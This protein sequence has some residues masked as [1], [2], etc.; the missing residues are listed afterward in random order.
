LV[1]LPPQVAAELGDRD[2][3]EVFYAAP[4][5]TGTAFLLAVA[6]G[7][8]HVASEQSLPATQRLEDLTTLAQTLLVTAPLYTTCLATHAHMTL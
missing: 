2:P 3:W 7:V 5:V 4:S 8:R 1:I 6:E